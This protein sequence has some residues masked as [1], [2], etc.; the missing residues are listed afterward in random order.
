MYTEIDSF[1]IASRQKNRPCRAQTVLRVAIHV[2]KARWRHASIA[3]IMDELKTE[4]LQR[5]FTNV[6]KQY[7]KRLFKYSG[8][9]TSST[10]TRHAFTML[11]ENE[12][13]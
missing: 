7:A 11:I 6:N 13:S 1:L 3:L 5:A 4:H 2:I 12:L 10:F 9:K 8:Y